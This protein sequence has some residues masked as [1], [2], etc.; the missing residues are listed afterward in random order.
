MRGEEKKEDVR[1][2]REGRGRERSVMGT[3]LNILISIEDMAEERILKV[4][5][6]T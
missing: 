4:K 5:A 1:E 6:D 2:K 3:S